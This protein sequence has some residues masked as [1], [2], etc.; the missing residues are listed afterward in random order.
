MP[1]APAI[2]PEPL[3][4][5]SFLARV[6]A[7]AALALPLLHLSLR[8]QNLKDGSAPIPER[9]FPNR[10]FLFIWRNW[11]LANSD[12][13]AKVLKTNEKTVRKLGGMLGYRRNRSSP[14]TNCAAFT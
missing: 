6:G 11:E 12:R 3:N 13:L 9:H 10:L 7:G 1:A 2:P 5:R 8:A 14:R 4:R